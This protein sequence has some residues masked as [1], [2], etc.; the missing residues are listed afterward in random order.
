M[1]MHTIDLSRFVPKGQAVCRVENNLLHMTTNRAIPSQRFDREHLP[2]ISYIHLPGKYRLPLR[3]DITAKIDAPGL[4]VL[5]GKGRVNFGTL[6]FDNR[7]IDD[8]VSP[9]RKTACYHNDLPMDEL[10]DISLIYDFKEMQILIG[11]EERYYSTTERYMSSR[12][13]RELNEDGFELK[14]TCDK[15]VNLTIQSINITEFPETCGI[16][17]SEAALPAAFTKNEAAAPGEKPTFEKC[18]SLLPENI[19]KEIVKMD[20]YLKSLKLFKFKRQIEKNGNKITYV[21][22]DFGFSYAIYLSNHLFDHSLQWY[23]IT[24]GKP[25]TWHRKADDM[26]AILSRLMQKNPDFAQRMFF[27][28]DDCVGCYKNCLGRTRYRLGAKSKAVCHGKL[29]FKMSPSGF[30]D[31]RVF[32]DEICAFTQG[33]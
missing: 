1:D 24:S 27:S 11:G 29:K 18:I 31:A 8:I 32:V 25:E 19:Q 21:A 22:S 23:L 16:V 20:E 2:I 10:T 12:E 7:R 26:E 9:A 15:L 13:F 4:Y 14:I 30:E 5:L 28:L 3:I 33:Q 17:H 6:C